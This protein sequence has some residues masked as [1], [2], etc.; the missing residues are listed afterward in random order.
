MT[1]YILIPCEDYTV[2]Q[3]C[4]QRRCVHIASFQ[5]AMQRVL[6][7]VLV[8]V[9]GGTGST[10][11]FNR[12]A[13]HAL[14]C[15]LPNRAQNISLWQTRAAMDL[16]RELSHDW[17]QAANG[18]RV[19]AWRDLSNELWLD[20]GTTRE[21]AQ[22]GYACPWEYVLRVV[23]GGTDA[24]LIECNTIGAPR[25]ASLGL[26]NAKQMVN[27]LASSTSG[28]VYLGSIA[29]D[30]RAPMGLQR[31]DEAVAWGR[32]KAS[33][34]AVALQ[35]LLTGDVWTVHAR[36]RN[37]TAGPSLGVCLGAQEVEF[38]LNVPFAHCEV[39]NQRK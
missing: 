39:R 26:L 27:V 25:C 18:L 17:M 3:F 14:A 34:T 11:A 13:M 12:I 33:H 10:V 21:F 6:K 36:R 8:T 32:A 19:F 28:F 7:D 5:H 22:R 24:A 4:A 2:A 38:K 23:V 31:T 29:H 15:W 9:D 37:G 20:P 1:G 30:E 16:E 35:A